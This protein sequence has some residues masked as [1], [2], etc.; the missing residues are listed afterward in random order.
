[1]SL[2]DRRRRERFEK[3]ARRGFRGYP[4]GTVAYYGPDDQRASKLVAAFIA[5][6]G[7]EPEMAKWYSRGDSDVRTDPEIIAEVLMFFE[8]RAPKSVVMVDRII[9]CPHEE[10]I[11]YPEGGYCPQCEF[12][13]NR[14]RFSGE[15]VQ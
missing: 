8:E 5:A 2:K 14:D 12:W 7:A 6:K 11:D 15:V 1:M 4:V 3:R 9:G 13:R 10:G